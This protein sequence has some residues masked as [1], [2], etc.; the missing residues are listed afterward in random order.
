MRVK[1]S[2]I[3]YL[4]KPNNEKQPTKC[5][6]LQPKSV[7]KTASLDTKSEI[8]SLGSSDIQRECELFRLIRIWV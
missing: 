1:N 4:T 3:R 5:E 8:L 2:M 6:I 7:N